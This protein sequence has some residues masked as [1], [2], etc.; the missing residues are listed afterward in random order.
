MRVN[1]LQGRPSR[2]ERLPFSGSS[3]TERSLKSEF[4]DNRNLQ[5]QRFLDCGND[6]IKTIKKKKVVAEGY[7]LY[8]LT[9]NKYFKNAV[10]I[11]YIYLCK[12]KP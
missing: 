6:E 2:L 1:L 4:I 8:L 10:L 9:E 5:F 7:D 3:E 11:F 12:I